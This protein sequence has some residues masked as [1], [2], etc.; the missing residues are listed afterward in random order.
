[1]AITDPV[2]NDNNVPVFREESTPVFREEANPNA[3]FNTPVQNKEQIDVRASN[4]VWLN[5]KGVETNE[6]TLD[7]NRDA[8]L[9]EDDSSDE[10]MYQAMSQVIMPNV[11][12][13]NVQKILEDMN[14]AVGAPD[15]LSEETTGDRWTSFIQQKKRSLVEFVAS[16][17]EEGGHKILMTWADFWP[18]S[19]RGVKELV[20]LE[21]FDVPVI[22]NIANFTGGLKKDADLR[23]AMFIDHLKESGH[24]GSAATVKIGDAIGETLIFLNEIKRLG[25][26]Y[27]GG[28]AKAT[29]RWNKALK[30]A[31]HASKISL[32]KTLTSEGVTMKDRMGIFGISMMY[33]STPALS[34]Q[35]TGKAGAVATDLFLNSLVSTFKDQGYTDIANDSD[36][37][38]FD[39][40]MAAVELF[41]AD[42][43][44]SSM[45]KAY[46][47]GTGSTL[48]A[49]G[50]DIDR[51]SNDIKASGMNPRASD[52]T[53]ISQ[54][55]LNVEMT[56]RGGI[57]ID[58]AEA[59]AKAVVKATKVKLEKD[60]ADAKEASLESTKPSP[61]DS[62]GDKGSE[63]KVEEIKLQMAQK[64]AV[65]DVIKET[66]GK[67]PNEQIVAIQR[68][69][70]Q[71]SETLSDKAPVKTQINR[72]NKIRQPKL[73]QEFTQ[74]DFYKSLASTSRDAV[75]SMAKKIAESNKEVTSVINSLPKD[76]RAE[77]TSLALKVSEA[78]TDEARETA[79]DK[80][81]EY[82]KVAADIHSLKLATVEYDKARKG[83]ES[84]VKSGEVSPIIKT[85]IEALLKGITKK[86]IDESLATE[87]DKL[88]TYEGAQMASIARELAQMPALD[89]MSADDVRTQAEMLNGLVH[90]MKRVSS[91][92]YE[93]GKTKAQAKVDSQELL[94][95]ANSWGVRP[96]RTGKIGKKR[97]A[98]SEW[99]R[100]LQ[101]DAQMV[102]RGIAESLDFLDKGAFTK[103]QDK[104][105]L[106]SIKISEVES[107]VASIFTK[108]T[109]YMS[110]LGYSKNKDTKIYQSKTESG[111]DSTVSLGIAD[112][113]RVFLASKDV[114]TSEVM[115][116]VGWKRELKEDKFF[117]STKEVDRIISDM[118][119]QE[120]AVGD[121]YISLGKLLSGY[122]DTRSM[123]INGYPLSQE[124]WTAPQ[125]R[126]GSSFL[127]K[128]GD[129]DFGV[130]IDKGQGFN[131]QMIKFSVESSGSLKKRTGSKEALLMYNPVQMMKGVE[132]VVSTYYG[133]ADALREANKFLYEARKGGDDSLQTKYA[134]AGRENTYN[135][136]NNYIKEL[137]GERGGG[138]S[139][140]SDNAL[141]KIFNW[142]VEYTAGVLK[143]NPKVALVQLASLPTASTVLS[144]SES[145]GMYKAFISGKSTS[146][147]EMSRRAP[148]LWSRYNGKLGIMLGDTKIAKKKER[149]FG[150]IKFMD[151]KVIGAI[152]TAKEKSI[153]SKNP[154][155]T[156]EKLDKAIEEAVFSVIM[157]TQPSFED[158][159]RPELARSSN[160]IARMVTIFS[161][162]RNK[163]YYL[164]WKASA[165]LMKKVD[166]NTATIT[167]YKNSSKVIGNL[168]IAYG[169]FAALNT[170]SQNL[171]EEV[172]D[173]RGSRPLDDDGSVASWD[174]EFTGHFI[175]GGVSSAGAVASLASSAASGFDVERTPISA[176]KNDAEALVSIFSDIGEMQ[177]AF[178]NGRG[179]E[180][181]QENWQMYGKHLSAWG[182]LATQTYSGV[183]IKNSYKWLIEAPLAVNRRVNPT[184]QQSV[185]RVRKMIDI[186]REQ[187]QRQLG[188]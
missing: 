161:S 17:T 112:R 101:F 26:S 27:G 89:K 30:T 185:D 20:G 83:A 9:D 148:Y 35:V 181:L 137:N 55:R 165:E 79:L 5:S 19:Y 21:D 24:I 78:K 96:P 123:E 169:V 183:N 119:A 86:S 70:E 31:T 98:V 4:S 186:E 77:V 16:G 170:A 167:D 184:V 67:T 28:A 139:N 114:N 100:K 136:F 143:M 141:K 129:M 56:G 84:L 41:G 160:P 168:L 81:V 124:G 166:S 29:G 92:I 108:H 54:A 45:T 132:R 39:K 130:N 118:P 175:K 178:S 14:S 72:I 63:S 146:I 34:G 38:G 57:E 53:P 179:Q 113:L 171:I 59:E 48:K 126:I 103:I 127:N 145:V 102:P 33:M 154:S 162:Q 172:M 69:T 163:N 49:D 93:L 135:T 88:D 18:S 2:F 159:S 105:E 120:R 133:R 85:Q 125:Y 121:A 68:R 156:G 76:V 61:K 44:F 91:E 32:F 66:E 131:E 43:V 140:S 37:D 71:I 115:K 97:D 15:S 11:S 64:E 3:L 52:N 134:K 111:K 6:A 1:M 94:L 176:A 110:K 8:Y 106:S 155:L 73:K 22:D 46:N 60:I 50:V 42:A 180:N 40:I 182:N 99:V 95:A 7:L 23:K 58:K 138:K 51:M 10:G 25:L 157:R 47:K 104:L 75:S 153:L 158:I 12:P 188:K 122:L 144:K 152:F 65:L 74:K 116:E 87:L 90:Q 177:E 13:I 164:G 150:G 187:D 62:D 109:D 149:G 107:S 174:G 147:E 80:F 151:S 117:L 82:A 142:G 173:M 36:M 128:Q